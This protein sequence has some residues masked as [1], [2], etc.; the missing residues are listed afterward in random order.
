MRADQHDP[1]VLLVAVAIARG[2]GRRRSAVRG[3]RAS[4][5]RDAAVGSRRRRAAPAGRPA[6]IRSP[7]NWPPGSTCQACA[8][9]VR[10]L[11]EGNA[12]G[13]E[14]WLAIDPTEQV[15]RWER[16]YCRARRAG[17]RAARR[18]VAGLAADRLAAAR[19]RSRAT[20]NAIRRDVLL[21]KLPALSSF[22]GTGRALAEE[23]RVIRDHARVQG[24]GRADIGRTRGLWGI[25]RRR[26]QIAREDRQTRISGVLR[27]FG[28]DRGCQGRQATAGDRRR[29]AGRYDARK[30]SWPCS[31]STTCC[32]GA[33]NL[34]VD[35]QQAELRRRMASQIRLLLVDE[36]QDT[37]RVQVELVKALCGEAASSGKLFFVG[38]SSSRSI[39][40]AAPI[41]TSSA[42][43]A[44]KRPRRANCR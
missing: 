38:D 23:L 2:G 39:A 25:S 36:F 31:I 24:A 40:S 15:E 17:H 32:S 16:Y 19:E 13:L 14:A 22:K 18:R 1:L 27:P 4:A 28:G 29:R 35:P 10:G 21:A 26:D 37:D 42:A 9:L 8:D 6:T 30:R 33:R 12:A 7:S 3:A 5:V 11:V 41:P 43:C 34:L 20:R 44:K